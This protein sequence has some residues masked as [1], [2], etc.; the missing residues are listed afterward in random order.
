MWQTENGRKTFLCGKNNEAMA[1]QAAEECTYYKED[2]EVELV[3]DEI[4]SCYN[5]RYR[6][7]TRESF[8][9]MKG[10]SG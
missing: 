9:C 8:E 3:S 7:W 6:R 5:C 10:D 4:V 2:S 1:L